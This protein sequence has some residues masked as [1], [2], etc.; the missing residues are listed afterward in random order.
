VKQYP[1][2]FSDHSSYGSALRLLDSAG[3]ADGVVLDLGCG[4]SPLAEPMAERGLIHVGCDVDTEAL[5]DLAA[6]GSE[7]HVVSLLATE[8]DLLARLTE[9]LDGRP[10]AAVLALDVLEHLPEPTPT[11]L[12]VR[13]LVLDQAGTSHRSSSASPTSPTSTSAPSWCSAVGTS[14]TPGC[15]TT[16][17][18][19]SSASTSW[20]A[21]SRSGVG[22]LP[23]PT[24]SSCR[25]RPGLPE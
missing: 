16:P 10:L 15:S 25:E 3:I 19:A 23:P 8:D 12:A 2:T 24:T 7:T 9:V 4:R 6:R 11:L 22:P 21:S 14:T 18:S 20:A 5:A 13:R 17:T 1:R